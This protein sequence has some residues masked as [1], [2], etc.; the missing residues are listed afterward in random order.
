MH[1]IRLLLAGITALKENYI[2]VEVEDQ[3]R[4][5]LLLIRDGHMSWEQVNQW[6]EQLHDQLD[7]AYSNT[8]I[9]ERP[10]YEQANNFLI[11]ARRE[12]L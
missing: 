11:K 2:V 5:D 8:S 12:A 1:L 10:D 9:P 7:R 4:D 6:R 3:Y